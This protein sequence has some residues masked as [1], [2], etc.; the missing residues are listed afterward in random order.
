V[1][2]VPLLVQV[3][4]QVVI[5]VTINATT[6]VTRMLRIVSRSIIS[7][8]RVAITLSAIIVM[9]GVVTTLIRAARI[10]RITDVITAV[11]SCVLAQVE[12]RR[13]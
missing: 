3:L 4:R 10:I 13:R 11:N 9:I 5:V 6:D 1:F 8:H 7:Q 12:R 2:W